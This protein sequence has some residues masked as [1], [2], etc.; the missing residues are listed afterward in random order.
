MRWEEGG[1]GVRRAR[2]PV[3]VVMR[4]GEGEGEGEGGESRVMVV[5]GWGVWKVVVW[6]RWWPERDLGSMGY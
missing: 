2:R 4:M 3:V 6:R 1:R 5:G